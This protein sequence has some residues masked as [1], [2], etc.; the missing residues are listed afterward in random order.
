MMIIHREAGEEANLGRLDSGHGF[1]PNSIYETEEDAIYG[2]RMTWDSGKYKLQYRDGAR[3]I[4]LPCVDVR[5]RCYWVGYEDGKGNSLQFDR[6]P[7]RELER[8]TASDHQGVTFQSDDHY[9][10][11]DAKTTSGQHISYQYDAAGCLARVQRTDGQIAFYQYDSGH[12]MTALSVARGPHAP[13]QKV[14]SNQYD[15]QGRVIR[16]TLAGV[17]AYTIEYLATAQQGGQ[18]YASELRIK[19]PAGQ[20]MRIHVG[21]EYVVRAA[22]VRFQRA[23]E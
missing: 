12:R 22:T 3:S 21:E 11:I 1:H 14:L 8:L 20:V 23:A 9:Q 17:G 19:N 15:V 16:Q 10:I 6:G 2:A 7:N 4:Y 5:V 13:V 18:K